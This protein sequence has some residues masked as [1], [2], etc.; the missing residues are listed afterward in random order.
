MYLFLLK[1]CRD[2]N[3]GVKALSTIKSKDLIGV[4]ILTALID[5]ALPTLKFTVDLFLEVS[6]STLLNSH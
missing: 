3:I 4:C 1:S 2:K 5:V 6:N